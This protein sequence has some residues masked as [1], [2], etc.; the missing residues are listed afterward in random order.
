MEPIAWNWTTEDTKRTLKK[1]F[2]FDAYT[3]HLEIEEAKPS[4]YLLSMLEKTKND[5]S[6]D[7]PIFDTAEEAIKWLNE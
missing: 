3:T 2:N 7:S 5:Q 6:G 1:R 4:K